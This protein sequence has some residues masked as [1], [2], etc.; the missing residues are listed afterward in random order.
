M[1]LYM[2]YYK[3]LINAASKLK[4]K[5]KAIALKT[6]GTK[7][8]FINAQWI[9]R[10]MKYY[11]ITPEEILIYSLSD[12]NKLTYQKLKSACYARNIEDCTK[13]LE[14]YLQ[15]PLFNSSE[16]QFLSSSIHRYLYRVAKKNYKDDNSISAVMSYLYMLEVEISDIIVLVEGIRYGVP[17]NELKKYLVHSL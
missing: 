1:K 11:E 3:E 6:I 15:Y 16:D 17:E 2:L 5:D 4:P 12:G 10:A 7:I 14:K 9:Y 13:Q 8:D